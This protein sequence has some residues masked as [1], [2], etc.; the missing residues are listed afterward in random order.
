MCVE[1]IPIGAFLVAPSYARVGLKTY[2]IQ[3]QLPTSDRFTSFALLRAT[4]PK[5]KKSKGKKR[6]RSTGVQPEH[7][8]R[9]LRCS[10]EL[11][12]LFSGGSFVLSEFVVH[13][14]FTLNH[15]P[16]A[17]QSAD[18]CLPRTEAVKRIWK[19]AK[20]HS[21][22]DINDGRVI[23][24]DSKL[25][26][27]FGEVRITMLTLAKLLSPH[28]SS[29]EAAEPAGSSR[30]RERTE[31]V[32]ETSEAVCWTSPALTRLMKSSGLSYE[33]T[34]PCTESNWK[35]GDGQ[36]QVPSV[37]LSKPVLFH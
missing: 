15:V 4:M 12:L 18:V 37:L 32:A 14:R 21:L 1:A 34:N 13:G 5:K 23:I 27:V 30:N 22:Q 8:K 24:C 11:A 20:D 35:V 10:R 3:L 9:D 19:Y 25:R 26:H 6:R 16:F 17:G 2:H 33:A 31:P 28:L 7:F 36:I 29:C